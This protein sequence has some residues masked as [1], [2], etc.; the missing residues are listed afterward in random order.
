MVAEMYEPNR[1]GVRI[2]TRRKQ[3]TVLVVACA[4]FFVIALMFTPDKP[5]LG[6]DSMG[7]INFYSART[8][9]YPIFLKAVAL[10]DSQLR[11]LVP[12][13]LFLFCSATL[14]FSMGVGRLTGRLWCAITVLVLMLGNYE[15]VKYG[16]W[17]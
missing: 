12:V 14:L 8:A 17:V 13:Q 7:Y 3:Q 6:G 1:P 16:F 15:V 2:A 5:L 4:A 9:G 10:L 11:A